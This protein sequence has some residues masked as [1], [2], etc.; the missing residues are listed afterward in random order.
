MKKILSLVLAALMIF[1]VL[2]VAFADEAVAEEVAA[3]VSEYQAAI[4]F[5]KLLG[6]YK[7]DGTDDAAEN[8]GGQHDQQQTVVLKE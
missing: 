1:S 4:D 2:P 8:N 7:G 3:E 5:L 6:I